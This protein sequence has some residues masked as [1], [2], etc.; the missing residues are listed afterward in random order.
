M[1]RTTS[2]IVS[3]RRT[4]HDNQLKPHLRETASDESDQPVVILHRSEYPSDF[5][6]IS[7]DE[8]RVQI[9]CI[10]DFIGD[11]N[12]VNNDS[13]ILGEEA[14]TYV[15]PQPAET[16][17]KISQ[18]GTG[19]RRSKKIRGE[20]TKKHKFEKFKQNVVKTEEKQR[21]W[22]EIV[23]KQIEREI[24]QPRGNVRYCVQQPPQ[25]NKKGVEVSN[26]FGGKVR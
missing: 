18:I 12:D 25:I 21:K 3:P 19:D 13:F 5:N 15:A 20:E 2:V 10:N 23:E 4:R 7:S 6:S 11:F 26:N 8:Q 1:A 17:Q 9:G 24:Q 22:N 16:R 14:A